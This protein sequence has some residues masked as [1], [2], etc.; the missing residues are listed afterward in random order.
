LDTEKM[1]KI[2]HILYRET[3]QKNKEIARL[4]GPGQYNPKF[5]LTGTKYL[6]KDYQRGMI[7]MKSDRFNYKYDT[8]PGPGNYGIPDQV[9]VAKKHFSRKG[10][11]EAG[12]RSREL[13]HVGS[14]LPPGAYNPEPGFAKKIT[15][16]VVSLKGPYELFTTDR[17]KY[18]TG[19]RLEQHNKVGPGQYESPPSFVDDLINNP[20]K[21]YHGR[22]HQLAKPSKK[23][24]AYQNHGRV[25][26]STLSMVPRKSCDPGPQTYEVARRP[27]TSYQMDPPFGARQKRFDRRFW[28]KFLGNG[29]NSQVGVGRYNPDKKSMRNVNGCQSAFKAPVRFDESKLKAIIQKKKK[30]KQVENE[31]R[32]ILLNPPI[33]STVSNEHRTAVNKK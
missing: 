8:Q 22:F 27:V 31:Q 33:Q 4:R 3:W 5:P 32:E 13:P 26:Q 17:G 10:M 25:Y 2:P 9:V 6:S 12:N 23:P 1:A 16:K 15:N 14:K 11:L 19:H 18:L 20:S 7:D 30:D 21:K 28:V 24:I 29:C